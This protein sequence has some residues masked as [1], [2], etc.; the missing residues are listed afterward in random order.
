MY[1]NR[2]L[3]LHDIQEL[4]GTLAETKRYRVPAHVHDSM[5]VIGNARNGSGDNA[6]VES[7]QGDDC[8]QVEHEKPELQSGR[9]DTLLRRVL[10]GVCIV[11]SR[12]GRD[13]DGVFVFL[14]LL[15]GTAGESVMTVVVGLTSILM[16]SAWYF[17]RFRVCLRRGSHVADRSTVFQKSGEKAE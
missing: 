1:S 10:T 6:H 11:H 4:K 9:I 3:V 14:H 8:A 2:G 16:T 15:C 5:K 17:S 12:V 13:F 7:V